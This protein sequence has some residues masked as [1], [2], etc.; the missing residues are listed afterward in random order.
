VRTQLYPDEGPPIPSGRIQWRG[1]VETEPFLGSR[2]HA[3]MGYGDRR[4]VVY[5]LS[6]KVAD[7]AAFALL[8]EAV[9]S[10]TEHRRRG[11]TPISVSYSVQSATSHSVILTSEC[12]S[13]NRTQQSWQS[14]D[15]I[16]PLP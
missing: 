1:V 9:T 13:R 6:K 14:V 3:T 5:P 2:T 8:C 12:A 11:F 10:W 15:E 16:A 7:L 4:A